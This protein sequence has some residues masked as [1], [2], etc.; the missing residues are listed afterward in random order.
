MFARH[1][2]DPLMTTQQNEWMGYSTG[3][4][5]GKAPWTWLKVPAGWMGMYGWCHGE[6]DG[7][8]VDYGTAVVS[9]PGSYPSY[10]F[11]F[12]S[13]IRSFFFSLSLSLFS[14][15]GLTPRVGSHQW[16]R[17]AFSTEPE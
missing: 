9:F 7:D 16:F 12:L 15:S 10:F 3:F 5:G 17:E 6:E 8:V 13:F 14:P 4:A 2:R 11:F 1:A